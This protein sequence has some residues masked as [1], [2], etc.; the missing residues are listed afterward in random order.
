MR[1]IFLLFFFTLPLLAQQQVI[2][3]DFNDAQTRLFKNLTEAVSTP[4]CQNGIPVAYHDSGMAGWVRD[5]I[6]A[7]I[8]EGKDKKE[9]TVL[10][11]DLRMGP[12][13]DMVLTF[14]APDDKLISQATWYVAPLVLGLGFLIVFLRVLKKQGTKTDL[15]DDELI[16]NYREYIT[17]QL[18]GN[19]PAPQE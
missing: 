9:I 11:K 1:C 8:R 5:K 15:D 13:G 14:T 17:A 19:K 3:D 12:K 18:K 6:S 2:P 4:C 16:E 10:L 7:W